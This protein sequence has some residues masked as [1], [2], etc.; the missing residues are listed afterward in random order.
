MRLAC[1]VGIDCGSGARTGGAVESWT[2]ADGTGAGCVIVGVADWGAGVSSL[3]I[4]R[5]FGP[6][7]RV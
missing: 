2:P 1:L 4:G 6:R 3:Q 5:C 7:A